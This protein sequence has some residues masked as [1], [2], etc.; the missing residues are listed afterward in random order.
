MVKLG[1]MHIHKVLKWDLTV[2]V[3]TLS[4]FG[5]H[6]RGWGT[7]V[8]SIRKSPRGRG[9][10]ISRMWGEKEVQRSLGGRAEGKFCVAFVMW[11]KRSHL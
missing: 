7:E 3:E 6:V 1:W 2:I 4:G 5:F 8:R 9:E 10:R 11:L